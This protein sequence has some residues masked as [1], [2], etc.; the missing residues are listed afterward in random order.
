MIPA[1]DVSDCVQLLVMSNL[2]LQLELDPK[3]AS[4]NSDPI[5]FDH[6]T[7]TIYNQIYTMEQLR[8]A[9]NVA[10]S[11]VGLGGSDETRG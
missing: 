6:I 4:L 7:E 10:A 8:Q 1:Y 9:A 3:A 5:L 2:P 11:Y